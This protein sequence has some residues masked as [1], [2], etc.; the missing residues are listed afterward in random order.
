MFLP[1]N[2]HIILHRQNIISIPW[3]KKTHQ[4]YTKY[5]ELR[6][7]NFAFI[8]VKCMKMLLLYYMYIYI[9]IYF[10]STLLYIKLCFIST[11]IYNK[12]YTNNTQAIKFCR[13]CCLSL[14]FHWLRPSC[15][16]PKYWSISNI[17]NTIS[18]DQKNIL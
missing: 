16:F 2:V 17:F 11:L 8:F 18:V 7:N 1:N 4:K 9:Y 10:I 12:E 5:N 13:R 15:T 14:M 6:W 3:Y